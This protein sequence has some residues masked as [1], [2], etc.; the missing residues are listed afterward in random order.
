MN[1]VYAY[2][3][4]AFIGF[5]CGHVAVIPEYRSLKRLRKSYEEYIKKLEAKVKGWEDK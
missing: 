1:N 3:F 5:I 2:I 4:M